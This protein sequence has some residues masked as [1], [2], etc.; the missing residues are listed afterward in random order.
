[1]CNGLDGST[2]EAAPKHRDRVSVSNLE[3]C[4]VMSF[5]L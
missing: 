3:T 4:S 1:M 2:M 5:I